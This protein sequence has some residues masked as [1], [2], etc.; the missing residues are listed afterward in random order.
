[1]KTKN[2]FNNVLERLSLLYFAFVGLSIFITFSIF[3]L[4]TGVLR[5]HHPLISSLHYYTMLY[6]I[7]LYIWLSPIKYSISGLEVLEK[8]KDKNI[9]LIANHRSHMDMFLL[10][11]NIYRLRAVANSY[12]FKVP[13]IGTIMSLSG[14]FKLEKGNITQYLGEETRIKKSI[15]SKDR[16]LFFPE[17]S[18]CPQGMKGTQKFRLIPFKIAREL[19][20]YIIP[21]AISNTDNVWPKYKMQINYKEKINIQILPPIYSKDFENTAHL[22]KYTKLMIEENI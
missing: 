22:A 8:V 11:A 9:I 5:N 4:L 20:A 2:Y 1:M 10:L 14:H 18:R 15:T 6:P 12:L 16:V 19:E 17:T 21:I 7:K 13:L 3:M